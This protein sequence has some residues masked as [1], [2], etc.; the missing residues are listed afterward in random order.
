M[1][2]MLISNEVIET[3][4]HAQQDERANCRNAEDERKNETRDVKYGFLVTFH[5]KN[6]SH[7][8]SFSQPI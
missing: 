8:K 4:A 7:S 2:G 6:I 1:R 5:E 3:I